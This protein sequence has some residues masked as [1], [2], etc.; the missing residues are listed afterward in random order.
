M[1]DQTLEEMLAMIIDENRH[2]LIDFG[3]P[4]G[5]EQI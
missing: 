1:E 4:V 2:E 3:H 5:K